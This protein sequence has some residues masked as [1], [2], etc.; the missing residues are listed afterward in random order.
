MKPKPL[1]FILAATAMLIAGCLPSL[2]PFY[3]PKDLIQDGR[4]V[5][6]FGEDKP[7]SQPDETWTFSKTD[8]DFYQL[9]MSVPKKDEA[10]KINVVG[11]ME[12]RLFKLGNQTFL[13]LKPRHD[14]LENDYSCCY[15]TS[16][17]AGHVLFKVHKIDDKALTMSAPEYDWINKH[18]KKHPEALAHKQDDGRLIL[19]DST[20]NLQA[21]FLKHD[22]EI[23]AEP[24]KMVRLKK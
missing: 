13:D 6:A 10:G 7:E 4:L 16:F 12:A 18:L 21:F 23:W 1:P 5:G 2:H 14:L 22:G 17:I 19:T 15:Q 11:Q 8:E 9:E 24:G 3:T 20:A